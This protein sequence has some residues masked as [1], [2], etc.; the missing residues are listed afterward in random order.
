M[1]RIF[2]SNYFS[3]AKSRGV[4]DTIAKHCKDFKINIAPDK[5]PGYIYKLEKGYRSGDRESASELLAFLIHVDKQLWKKGTEE[6]VC[7]DDMY[8]LNGFADEIVLNLEMDNTQA[9]CFAPPEHI[10]EPAYILKH[11]NKEE[12]NR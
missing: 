7:N 10:V 4:F 1:Q 11:Q 6:I 12:D 8:I 5:I 9:H 3:V 2:K